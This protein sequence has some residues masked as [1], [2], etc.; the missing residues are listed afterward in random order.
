MGDY[1][2]LRATMEPKRVEK[3]HLTYRGVCQEPYGVV[4]KDSG[5]PASSPRGLV[6]EGPWNYPSP[7]HNTKTRAHAHTHTHSHTE[8][9]RQEPGP[10][11]SAP[12]RP[13]SRV[14]DCSAP[15]WPGRSVPPVCLGRCTATCSPRHGPRG[16]GL[17]FGARA[18]QGI[19][20][21]SWARI[22]VDEVV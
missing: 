22:I 2:Q 15:V 16:G 17:D 9:E 8:R 19:W 7:L 5:L 12:S 3:T 18:G 1:G 11:G 6:Q 14:A 13:P 20:W 10:D 21:V 4:K